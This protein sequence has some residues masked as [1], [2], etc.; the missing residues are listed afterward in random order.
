[1]DGHPAVSKLKRFKS[2]YAELRFVCRARVRV[3]LDQ[4]RPL[5]LALKVAST[6]APPAGAVEEIATKVPR[7]GARRARRFV[8]VASHSALRPRQIGPI[9]AEF[10]AYPTRVAW[11]EVLARTT[12]RRLRCPP[13]SMHGHHD[14]TLATV[15]MFMMVE[16]TPSLGQPI[17]KCRAFHYV[18]LFASDLARVERRKVCRLG[19]GQSARERPLLL[20]H[21]PSEQHHCGAGRCRNDRRHQPTAERNQHSDVIADESTGNTH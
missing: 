21:P 7:D 2:Y 18:L 15:M 20:S 4:I 6:V 8:R 19:H 11:I 5:Q 17:P 1:V 9:E 3:H 13:F 10:L 14:M 12:K 16:A